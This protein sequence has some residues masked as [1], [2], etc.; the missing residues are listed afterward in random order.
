MGLFKVGFGW[1]LYSIFFSFQ[2]LALAIVLFGLLWV[3]SERLFIKNAGLSLSGLFV[4]VD[5]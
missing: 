3:S 2:N 1:F 5:S 4:M